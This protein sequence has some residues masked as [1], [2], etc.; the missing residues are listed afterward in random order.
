MDNRSNFSCFSGTGVSTFPDGTSADGGLSYQWYEINDGAIG[1][2]TRFTGAGTSTL[3]LSHG[4][5][6][7]DNGNQYFTVTSRFY[8]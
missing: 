8:T 2:S 6:P 7:E 5:S 1:V 3:T 4:L